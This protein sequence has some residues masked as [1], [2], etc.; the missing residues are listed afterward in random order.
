MSCIGTATVGKALLLR[1][2]MLLVLVLLLL[3]PPPGVHLERHG[4]HRIL[5]PREGRRKAAGGRAT[6]EVRQREKSTESISRID[7]EGPKKRE[8]AGAGD[9][10]S[11]REW[12]CERKRPSHRRDKDAR[13][14]AV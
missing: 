14:E 8:K 1:L 13:E 11:K 2:V 4:I 9:I 5:L 6:A 10:E 12:E 3:L 7:R